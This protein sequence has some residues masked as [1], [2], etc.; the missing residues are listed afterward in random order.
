MVRLPRHGHGRAKDEAITVTEKDNNARRPF[1]SQERG[2]E[3]VRE[4]QDRL[5]MGTNSLFTLH[6]AGG[7]RQSAA[8]SLNR[9]LASMAGQ[10]GRAAGRYPG[11]VS[12]LGG[13]GAGDGAVQV[14]CRWEEACLRGWAWARPGSLVQPPAST[15]GCE[16]TWCSVQ[17]ARLCAEVPWRDAAVRCCFLSAGLREEGR[18]RRGRRRE[19]CAPQKTATN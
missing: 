13:T 2:G 5:D 12:P 1:P 10:G 7:G 8:K 11:L 4:A 9:A 6:H 18:G 15:R 3:T 19:W 17:A 16:R 14:R